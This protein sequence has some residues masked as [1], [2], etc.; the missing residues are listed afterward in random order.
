MR[1]RWR[2]VG[3][4]HGRAVEPRRARTRTALRGAT[5]ALL[6]LTLAAGL[7]GASPARAA[8]DDSDFSLDRGLVVEYWRDGGSGV[9]EAAE[10]ALLGGDDEI[11]A[12]IHDQPALQ[13]VD[14][15]VDVSRIINAGGPAV[16]EAAKT[17]LASQSPDDVTAFLRGGWKAPLEQDQRV[18]ASRVINLGGP[19]VQDAGKAALKGSPEDVAKFLAE[20]QYT[21]RETDN[22]VQVSQLIGSGGPAMKAAG[23]V[24]LQGTPEDI[25]EFL[26]VGQ[27]TARDRDQEHAT[28]AQLTEQAKQA[29]AQADDATKAAQEA[30]A[31]AVAAAA[32]AK[33]AAQTAAKETAAAKNDSFRAAA[34]A[35]QAADAARAA[36]EAAQTAIG[37]ANAADRSARIAALAAAQTAAAA[38]AAANAAG[39][40]YK[41]AA[42]AASDKNKA[43]SARDSAKQARA[44]GALAKSS[45]A[46]A[47]QAGR[48]SLAA[49]A[50]A[51]ASLSATGD[52]NAA[53]DAA[54]DANRA[55]D[56][57]GVHSGEAQA[58]AAETRRHAREANRAANAAEAL[59]GE[60][61]QA[62][63]D[64][65]DAANS[66]A[67]HAENAADAAEEAAKQAGKATNAANEA[68]KQ[69]AKAKEA[70]D[71]AT[72]AAATA[73]KVFTIARKSEV[74]DLATRTGAAMETAQSQK[75]AADAFT[76]QLAKVALEDKQIGE[77][78]AA[79]AAEADKSGAD[80]KDIAVKGRAVALRALKQYGAW[81]QEAA[82]Q[83]LSGDDSAVLDYLRTGAKQAE[84]D[85]IRQQVTDL[86]ATS[87]YES[88]R[89]GATEALGGSDQQIRDFYT[90]GQYTVATADYRVLVSQI[91]N[92]D[93]PAV[94]DA[95]KA[96]LADGSPNAMRQFLNGGQYQ[97]RNQ[98]ERVLASKLVNDGGPEVQA[99]AKI[100]LTG[101]A[102]QLH[103][104][105]QVGQYMADRKDKLAQTHT[106]Q[107]Q[108]LLNEADGIAAS[109]RKDSW[110][111]AKAAATAKNAKDEANKA[112]AQAQKSA[113]Q[114]GKYAADAKK[115]ADQAQD[116]AN[117][118]ATSAKTA[119]NASD[120]ADQD[121]A[122]ADES[123]SQAEWSA[124]YARDT[125]SAAT[126]AADDAR[127]DATA[128]GKSAAEAN[129]EASKA[130]SDVVTKRRAE[131]A[132]ARKQAEDERKQQREKEKQDK[133]R[134]RCIAYMSRDSLPPCALAGQTLELPQA[135]PD[136]AKLLLKG[137]M[138]V[139]GVNDLLDCA[140][141]PT[142]GQ[143]TLAVA[144]VLPIG[145]LK[146][147]KKAAE[148]VED[149]AEGSRAV[150]AAERCFQ[151][152]LA[153]TK[154]LMADG[155]T[156]NIE[157]VKIGDSV[158]ATDPLTGVTGA[159]AVT[160]RIVT[161]HDKRFD[162]LTLSTRRGTEHLTATNEHP[163]W[164][165][166]SGTWV[167]AGNLRAGATLRT[168][169]GST[170]TVRHNRSFEGTARTYN[171]TIADLH[172]YYVLAGQT[173]VLVH[174]SGPG[175]GTKWMSSDKLPHHYMRTSD[176]GV[177]HA[178]DFGIKGPYNKANGQK[179]IRAVEQ[180]VKNPNTRQ[181]QGTFRGQPA[182]HYVDDTGLH[183]SFA[184]SGPNVGEYLGGWKSYGDQLTYLLQ[185]GKL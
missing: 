92:A 76:S 23:K 15:R 166:S 22:R 95:S 129:T 97:A 156:K 119:R 13:A 140:K 75:D 81:R 106:A 148:G 130:W 83:A 37:A 168:V 36:A 77:D 160:R 109:A 162:E 154:V 58:A 173:P 84:T 169:D 121:A 9:K 102:D 48:A 157:S 110:L 40:A 133:S 17:A 26:E 104:F 8:D 136:L 132:A 153:G 68:A 85:E 176:K 5:T 144:G 30:S 146:L 117:Q 94:K 108:R 177:M 74:E 111:A 114:A 46:A 105:I 152:F 35:R 62:A 180:F 149:I 43:D 64:A 135:S 41:A 96:A 116:S 151:C 69:A 163:F 147:L 161:E 178:E 155:A 164:S 88:V 6:P 67:T 61:A 150:K 137:G 65:R 171:L 57:A 174:N 90:T 145:K 124:T 79:L 172:T 49:G 32:L 19:G 138:E 167:K 122:D 1:K 98:D 4:S 25:V 99:A 115:S 80:T 112:A 29:G 20:G 134:K 82:A 7:L 14:D 47:E 27:F 16:R 141:D 38:T 28:I 170:V 86:A 70:A 66:A 10:R 93:G 128:A 165:P 89:T 182:I 179:F 78:T 44:A 56:A 183:A 12:F 55:A 118:A 60:S 100:A 73:H 50:A 127:A 158:I 3:A 87:P 185:D 181:I 45:A 51:K 125:A 59:A 71:T 126:Y 131:E 120:R 34:K 72:T 42:D 54:D 101:P 31:K 113:D 18:E 142:L 143:C 103:D 63:Y 123:A 107:M 53:A 159:R 184:A 139:L 24:A 52:A 33:A 175:C 11:R 39:A 91:N 2:P 21:A